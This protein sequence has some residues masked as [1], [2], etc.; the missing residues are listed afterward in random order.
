MHESRPIEG[1]TSSCLDESRSPH[2]RVPL[3]YHAYAKDRRFV[4]MPPHDL[5]T[6]W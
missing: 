3:N 2:F 4:E 1:Q 5:D 6:D